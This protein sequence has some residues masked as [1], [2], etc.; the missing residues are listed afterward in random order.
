MSDELRTRIPFFIVLENES[1]ILR[2][3]PREVNPTTLDVFFPSTMKEILFAHEFRKRQLI[4]RFLPAGGGGGG[5]GGYAE[6]CTAYVMG[7]G[8]RQALL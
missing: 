8:T 7:S 6:G 3:G 2:Q 4:E 1:S 5:G